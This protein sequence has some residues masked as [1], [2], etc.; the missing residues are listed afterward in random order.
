MQWHCK[1]SPGFLRL[2]NVMTYLQCVFMD[3]SVMEILTL[4]LN[5]V[6]FA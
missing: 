5:E 6:N 2:R 3:S 1:M 4:L